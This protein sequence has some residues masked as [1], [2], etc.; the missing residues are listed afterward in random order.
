MQ[1]LITGQKPL[2]GTVVISGAK[3]SALK[4]IVAALLCEGTTTI[5]NVPRIRDIESLLEI[6]NY[7]GGKAEFV[8]KN[9]VTVSN[10]LTKHELPLEIASKTRVS[11]LLI[12]PLL[13]RF[14]KAVLPNPGGCRLGE[15]SVDRLVSSVVQMGAEI[16]YCSN[17]GFY[18]CQLPKEQP[19]KIHF[20]KKSHTGTELAIMFAS[21][22]SGKT[23]INNAA[24]EPEIDDL[25][26][27]LNL[28]G[29]KIKR[30][31]EQII[32]E[33]KSKLTA[34]RIT[35]QSDRI[36]A[37]TFIVLSAL[38]DGKISLKRAPLINLEPFFKP[39]IQA[40]YGY[41]YNKD[42]DLLTIGIP[43]QSHATEIATSPHPGFLT[44]WQPLWTLLMTQ[45]TGQSI[46]HET[47]F[48]NRL[49]YVK[50]LRRFGAKIEFF[51]P[52]VKDPEQLYQFNGYSPEKHRFQA[53]KIFGPTPLHNG[54]AK[55]TDI[56]AGA[57]LVLA[58]LIAKGSSVISG[59][60]QIE[61]GYEA[62]VDKLCLLGA[63][64]VPEA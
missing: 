61:R 11:I 25:I 3:N 15:R 12:A 57:C 39:F 43:K 56:R 46:V 26:K 35:V 51:Q 18:H 59:V 54:F 62:L 36:E 32:V 38:F 6:I 42:S 22:I 48:E 1:Y 53:I 33:G 45:A 50:D 21:R 10:H 24:L 4:L 16:N 40:G 44:D 49:S 30:E 23:I 63:N 41:D 5:E 14:K 60:E 13:H 2:A 17:D 27:L 8:A 9:T 31:K 19:G 58:A 28:S 7:L 52:K 55:M 34:S 64:I 20:A 29:A 47:V 37:A